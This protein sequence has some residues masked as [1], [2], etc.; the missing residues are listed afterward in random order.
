MSVNKHDWTPYGVDSHKGEY[1]YLC[2]KCGKRDWIASY[3]TM[4][5]L[6]DDE[7]IASKPVAV[8]TEPEPVIPNQEVKQEVT[9]LQEFDVKLK[10]MLASLSAAGCTVRDIKIDWL[11]KL[12]GTCSVLQTNYDVEMLKGTKNDN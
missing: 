12:N 10:E 4:S 8:T 3:G 6:S 5:Q 7:C 1:W 2:K 11:H 9:T